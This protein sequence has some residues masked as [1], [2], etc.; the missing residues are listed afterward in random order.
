MSI[1]YAI[2]IYFTQK[3]N[4]NDELAVSVPE[5]GILFNTAPLPPLGVENVKIRENSVTIRGPLQPSLG[6]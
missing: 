3:T 1:F 5:S 2:Y 6:P 4:T